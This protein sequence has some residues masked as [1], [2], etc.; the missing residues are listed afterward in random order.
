MPPPGKEGFIWPLPCWQEF[1][2][3]CGAASTTGLSSRAMV[4]RSGRVV[5]GLIAAA[6]V[7]LGA[8]IVAVG[9]LGRLIYP[10]HQ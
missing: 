9:R 1:S 7:L 2:V 4:R 3:V 10:P 5:A 8:V 6:A